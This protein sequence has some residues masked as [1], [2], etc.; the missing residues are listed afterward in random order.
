M[1]TSNASNAPIILVQ[2]LPIRKPQLKSS[3]IEEILCEARRQIRSI[4]GLCEHF[5]SDDL[6]RKSQPKTLNY[7]IVNDE[8]IFVRC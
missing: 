2:N 8:I 6:Y 1:R 4:V 5:V 7:K 3:M